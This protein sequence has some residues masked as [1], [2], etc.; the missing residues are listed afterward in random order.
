MLDRASLNLLADHLARQGAGDRAL[1]LY[2]QAGEVDRAADAAVGIARDLASA[3]SWATLA[4]MGE[5]LGKDAS[6][7]QRNPQ[8]GD[9]NDHPVCR[10]GYIA[11]SDE[12]A[13]RQTG[14]G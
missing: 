7:P 10:C 3:G 9:I 1:E 6:A 8:P 2:I 5:V 13:D 14:Q 11:S 4:R 12:V